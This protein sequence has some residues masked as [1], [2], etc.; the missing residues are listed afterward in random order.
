MTSFAL[1]TNHIR[2]VIILQ[3]SDEDVEGADAALH[4][5]ADPPHDPR[6]MRIGSNNSICL[7]LSGERLGLMQ[8]L[9][10]LAALL[11]KYSVEPAPSSLRHPVSDPSAIITQSIKGGLPLLI[12]TRECE[13]LSDRMLISLKLHICLY[14]RINSSLWMGD[15]GHQRPPPPLALV[16]YGGVVSSPHQMC[17]E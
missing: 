3:P 7:L 1:V 14:I 13:E 8:S 5:T 6:S 11:H 17:A 9:A 2:C 4:R 15:R 10:G 12:K 16:K